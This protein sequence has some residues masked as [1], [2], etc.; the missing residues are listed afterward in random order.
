MTRYSD[1]YIGVVAGRAESGSSIENVK[2]SNL[3]I[4]VS[5]SSTSGKLS[6][7]VVLLD[8]TQGEVL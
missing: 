1:T 2:V 4:K 3:K 7:L 6:M 5:T 8:K